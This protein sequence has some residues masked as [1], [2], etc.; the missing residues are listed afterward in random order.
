MQKSQTQ[1]STQIYCNGSAPDNAGVH[2]RENGGVTFSELVSKKRIWF[3]VTSERL[4]VIQVYSMMMQCWAFNSEDRPTFSYLQ[5]LIESS[6]Q[7][8]REGSKGW[9]MYHKEYTEYI[10][11]VEFY[12]TCLLVKPQTITHSLLLY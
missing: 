4:P 6:L 1:G 10:N 11:S 5:D 3:W 9:K 7:D 8:E 12:V 2:E